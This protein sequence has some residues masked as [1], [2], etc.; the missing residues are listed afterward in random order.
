M[1]FGADYN[2]GI[3]TGGNAMAANISMDGGSN[4]TFIANL[5]PSSPAIIPVEIAANGLTDL[6]YLNG[7]ITFRVSSDCDDQQVFD[8][9]TINVS[10][11]PVCSPITLT[12]PESNWFVNT[13]QIVSASNS[14]SQVGESSVFNFYLEGINTRLQN[15]LH[16]GCSG[17]GCGNDPSRRL[18]FQY[19]RSTSVSSSDIGWQTFATFTREEIQDHPSIEHIGYVDT[20]FTFTEVFGPVSPFEDPNVQFR[21]KTVCELYQESINNVV[22]GQIDKV[23]PDVFG[24]ALP[25]DGVFEPNNELTIRFNEAM[26]PA[27]VNVDDIVLEGKF[28]GLNPWAGA[29]GF[30][31]SESIE[32]L[33]APN[34]MDND[35]LATPRCG[36]KAREAP[37][38]PPFRVRCFTRAMRTTTCASTSMATRYLLTFKRTTLLRPNASDL[39]TPGFRTPGTSWRLVH[40]SSSTMMMGTRR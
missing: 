26:N 37:S 19:L 12:T 4:S 7:Q 28:N 38:T 31:G 33:D 35:W 10:F 13:N 6:E 5:L 8:L 2:L 39:R 15:F 40:R 36:Q 18:S 17:G 22:A 11:D 34:I 24:D 20:T 32:V 23:R 25:L 9:L 29:F 14:V 3:E 27:S 1:R 21:A 16:V 30:D